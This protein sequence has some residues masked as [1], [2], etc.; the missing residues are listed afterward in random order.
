[1]QEDLAGML[2]MV[3]RVG[4][5]GVEFAGYHGRTARELRQMLDENHLVAC[6]THTA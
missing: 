1:M 5:Q 3:A 4:Y 2:S 6:G